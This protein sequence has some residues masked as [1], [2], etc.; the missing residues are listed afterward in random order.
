MRFMINPSSLL[1]KLGRSY[2]KKSYERLVS[3]DDLV[4]RS[5]KKHGSSL[6]GSIDLVVGKE[7]KKYSVSLKYFTHPK[8]Q[9]LLK[10]YREPVF[11]PRFGEPIVLEYCSTETFNQLLHYIA[12]NQ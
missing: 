2:S 6:K 9:E 1:N 8:L 7:E 11:D 12:K 4:E 5:K 10:K 3:E